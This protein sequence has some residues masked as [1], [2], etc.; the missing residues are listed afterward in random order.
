MLKYSISVWE[1]EELR[2]LEPQGETK[3]IS[4]ME[5]LMFPPSVRAQ[6]SSAA[7][8]AVLGVHIVRANEGFSLL[9]CEY[10]AMYTYIKSSFIT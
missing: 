8:T 2:V 3:N 6:L 1:S 9:N 7:Q 5:D 10:F 4:L